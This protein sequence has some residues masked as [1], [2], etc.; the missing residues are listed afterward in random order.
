MELEALQ[1][2]QINT[3]SLI[4]AVFLC[5]CIIII[6]M[7]LSDE[8]FHWFIIPTYLCGILITID[9]VNWMRGKIN[10]LDPIGF[11]GIFG[12]HFF[13]L[14]PLLQV[15][16]DFDIPYINNNPDD[17]RKWVGYLEILN[18]VGLILYI[19]TRTYFFNKIMSKNKEQKYYGIDSKKFTYVTIIFLFITFSLQTFIYIK[20]RGI[21]GY[22]QTYTEG[23]EG[24]AGMGW[25]FMI[26]ESFPI[27]LLF[28]IAYKNNINNKRTTYIYITFL[29]IALFILRLYFGGLRGSRSN[30]L[31][32]LIWGA[33][34]VHLW[35]KP[36][37]RRYIY[38][39]MIF[40]LLF[41]YVYGI[42]KGAHERIAE[43]LKGNVTISELADEHNRDMETVLLGDLARTNIQS[44]IIYRQIE[45]QN[46]YRLSY[47]RSYLGDLSILIPKS[48]WP[49]RPPSKVKE[50]TEII[51][52]TG[53][54]TPNGYVSSR[55]HGLLGEFMLNFGYYFSSLT[56]IIFSY[57]VAKVRSFLY[58]WNS[59]DIRT[60]LYPFLLISTFLLLVQDLD[61]FIFGIV[62]NFSIPLLIVL[63]SKKS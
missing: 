61:N 20:Y 22:I 35:I 45:F 21:S 3:V 23:G 51:K 37:S 9:A 57:F 28:L 36:L 62:K 42:Y 46:E 17:W 12:F 50:G 26:S 18:L 60:L 25:L 40:L 10:L 63:F 11:I 53:S 48:I 6:F 5:T 16:W 27:L 52:G 33:G 58:L 4:I 49:N 56:F 7:L 30:T 1:K 24:F 34:I 29:F 8:F 54:Y 41:I 59:N 55:I 14:A 31:W 13:F 2:K 32:V 15:Y 38:L 19:S 43:V 44:Y 39:G 47:G